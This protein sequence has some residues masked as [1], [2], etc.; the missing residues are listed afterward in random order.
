MMFR[1]PG[2][3]RIVAHIA[4]PGHNTTLPHF[5]LIDCWRGVDQLATYLYL[6]PIQVNNDH[7]SFTQNM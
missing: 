4:F 2:I 1:W 6:T 7:D 3:P 5:P